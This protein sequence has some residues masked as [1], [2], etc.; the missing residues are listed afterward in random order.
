MVYKLKFPFRDSPLSH[1]RCTLPNIQIWPNI[2]VSIQNHHRT[3]FCI[4]ICI[5]LDNVV[6]RP[7]SRL[8]VRGRKLKWHLTVGRSHCIAPKHLLSCIFCVFLCFVKQ[9]VT[10]HHPKTSGPLYLFG[11]LASVVS[12]SELMKLME[13]IKLIK[14]MKRIK[15][16]KMMTKVFPRRK[17]LIR[18]VQF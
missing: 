12:H 6:Q 8:L 5:I 15:I 2:Q 11:V 16:M 18:V 4:C 7:V 14:T 13:M 17:L 10:L 9:P 3:P 1:V